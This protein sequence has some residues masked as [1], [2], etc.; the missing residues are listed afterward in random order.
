MDNYGFHVGDRRESPMQVRGHL[1][2]GVRPLSELVRFRAVAQA[3][4]RPGPSVRKPRQATSGMAVTRTAD[5]S[6]YVSFAGT[7]YRVGRA[8]AG[9]AVEV[10]IVA[11]SVP[12]TVAGKVVRI[13]PV[14]HDPA[15]EHGAFATP[16]GR[17]RKK[18]GA[19]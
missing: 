16:K 5:A 17:P 10:S 6:G 13:H 18:A 3:A 11:G 12:L 15:A 19:A 14:R 8:H 9:K 7:G 1:L 4:I 2:V